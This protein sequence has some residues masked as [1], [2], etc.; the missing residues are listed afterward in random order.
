MLK[1][2]TISTPHEGCSSRRNYWTTE[3]TLEILTA[4]GV[5][6][7]TR[8]PSLDIYL[9][10][11][12]VALLSLD[13]SEEAASADHFSCSLVGA[14]PPIRGHKSWCSL[15][16]MDGRCSTAKHLTQENRLTVSYHGS[17]STNH[18]TLRAPPASA[19]GRGAVMYKSAVVNRHDG[20]TF[21]SRARRHPGTAERTMLLP[22]GHLPFHSYCGKFKP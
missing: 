14:S 4:R 18:T 19:F 6:G 17:L 22:A 10:L 5:G 1:A 21:E 11:D 12:V 15:L 9:S 2:M 13:V 3:A 20:K 8:R 16:R 7:T